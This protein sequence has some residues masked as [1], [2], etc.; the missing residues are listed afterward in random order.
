[1]ANDIKDGRLGLDTCKRIPEALARHLRIGFAEPGD[2]LLTHKGTVGLTTV[3]PA[4]A[5]EFIMLTPQVTYYRI[6]DP[7]QLR[8]DFLLAAFSSEQ[9]QQ[10]FRIRAKQSTRD[11]V[12]ILAQRDLPLV[13]P[14]LAQQDRILEL[15]NKVDAAIT[16]VKSE[17][18]TL[19]ALSSALIEQIC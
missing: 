18:L 10:C 16:L 19:G 2:V 11:Y 17:G 8:R 13:I 4:D 7:T 5:G 9:F 12:G 15:L 6:K 1:M 3:V 14:N